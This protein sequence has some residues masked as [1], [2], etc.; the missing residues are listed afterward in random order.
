MWSDIKTKGFTLIEVM[1]AVFVLIVGVLGAFTVV[2]NITFSSQIASSKLTATY[3]AQEGIELVRNQRDSNWLEDTYTP[4]EVPWDSNVPPPECSRTIGKFTRNC[5]VTPDL[6]DGVEKMLVSVE[7]NW[8]ERGRSYQV[9]A[10]TEL[11][12]WYGL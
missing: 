10:K 3:L 4:A 8:E 12:N 9:T 1:V 6:V 11:Y 5:Q 7:V 2:Q